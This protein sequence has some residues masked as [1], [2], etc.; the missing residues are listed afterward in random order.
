MSPLEIERSLERNTDMKRHLQHA[1]AFAP[2]HA[3]IVPS[4]PRGIKG[5]LV[6]PLI[7]LIVALLLFRGLGAFGVAALASWHT[8][9][10]LALAA[11]FCFTG[12]AHFNRTRASLVRM[13]PRWMPFP[14]QIVTATGILEFFGALGLVLPGTTTLAAIGLAALLVAMFPANVQ[15]AR[16]HLAIGRKPATPLWFRTLVQIAFIA[17]LLWV[18]W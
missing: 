7:V 9:S 8:A 10:R 1:S 17:L 18:A 11:M 13:V 4:F 3:G 12:I 15:T 2:Q 6:A 16:Q 5:Y 14:A